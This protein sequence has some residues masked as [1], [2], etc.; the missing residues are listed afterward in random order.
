MISVVFSTRKDNQKHIKHIEETSGIY[1]DLEVIQYIND[2]EYSLTQLYNKALKET[3]NDIVVF[4]HDDIIFETKNWGKKILSHFKRNSDYGILGK[5]GTKYLPKSGRWWDCGM[6]EVIG[7]VYHQNEG[8]KWLSKYSEYFGNKIEDTII[9]DGLFFVVNKNNIK[10]TFDENIKGFHFYEVDFC[11]NNFLNDVKVGVIS[12]ISITHLSIGQTNDQ[13]ENN[14]VQ[15]VEKYEDKLP[16]IIPYTYDIKK[17]KDKEPLVSILMPIYNYG[18]R[19]NQTLNSVF[20]QDYTNYEIILVDDGSTDEFVKMKLKQLETVERVKV[21]YK[22]NG[23]PSSARNEAFKH[24]KGE[25]ILPLDSDDMVMDG[26]IKTCVNILSTN[27]NISPVYCDTHHVGQMQG[28]EQR[29]EWSKE[30][31][32]QGPFIVNC[33]MFHRE[34]FEKVGGYDEELNGWEDYDMWLRMMKE[35]YVGKR[36]PKPLFIYFHHENDGTVS[37][38]ANKNSQELYLKIISKNFEIKDNKILVK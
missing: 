24:S 2:G 10:Q 7:Q 12:D 15:F 4:C 29:P 17:V 38:N 13:W 18:N 26:Y 6:T 35:G 36:I 1:K 3:T 34:S 5:A 23:G 28:V 20:N 22:E 33:S 19:I 32:V 25:F 8:K 16:Q 9:V 27:K 11:F 37:T 21:V 30:R 14:R 31:L